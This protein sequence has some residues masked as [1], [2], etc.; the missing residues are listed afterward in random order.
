MD[1][2]NDLCYTET[3]DNDQEV[4][5]M[6][7]PAE[8]LEKLNSLPKQDY[9]MIVN[10]IDRLSQSNEDVPDGVRRF[11]ELRKKT[12]ATPMTDEEVDKEITEARREREKYAR[13]N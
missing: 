5:A 8:T 11:R 13:S 10:L 2:F 6:P 9:V 1:I 12:S 4:N 3:E 7:E